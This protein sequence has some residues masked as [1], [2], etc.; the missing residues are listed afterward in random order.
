MPGD[1]HNRPR[2]R[3]DIGEVISP[4]ERLLAAREVSSCCIGTEALLET[5]APAIDDHL[6]HRLRDKDSRRY[7]E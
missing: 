6:R 4:I 2:R 7:E 1:K 3:Q 5:G